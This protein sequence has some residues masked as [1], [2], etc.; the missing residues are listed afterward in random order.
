MLPMSKKHG[1]VIKWGWRKTVLHNMW[2]IGQ[3][4]RQKPTNLVLSPVAAIELPEDEIELTWLVK[5]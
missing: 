3:E 4:Q 2:T 5:F 1:K